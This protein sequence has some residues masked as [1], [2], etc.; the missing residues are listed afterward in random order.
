MH[1]ALRASA[2]KA[3]P[4]TL[5]LPLREVLQA[6]VRAAVVARGHGDV[7]EAPHHVSERDLAS[8]HSGA[9]PFQKRRER[10]PGSG[11]AVT[12]A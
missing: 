7:A 11:A 6:D 12:Y 9:A 8:G 3:W 2:A 1:F 4:R 10:S 5:R